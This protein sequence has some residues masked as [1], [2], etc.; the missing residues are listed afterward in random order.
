MRVTSPHTNSSNIT[1]PNTTTL[2][3]PIALS[4]SSTRLA[5][6]WCIFRIEDMPALKRTSLFQL[7][8][9]LSTQAL[10]E[11][12][13]DFQTVRRNIHD[14]VGMAFLQTQLLL[15]RDS[16]DA[17]EQ[18]WMSQRLRPTAYRP[19]PRCARC[20]CRFPQTTPNAPPVL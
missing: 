1:S 2:R 16:R 20:H 7:L 14:T 6:K 18:C 5:D 17:S 9:S 8:R 4:S 13:L 12:I 11:Y 10:E 19:R 15:A 3:V